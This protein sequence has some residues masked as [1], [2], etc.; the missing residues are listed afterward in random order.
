[1]QLRHSN[2]RK[3]PRD[4]ERSVRI[5]GVTRFR[6]LDYFF[7]TLTKKVSGQTGLR[8]GAKALKGRKHPAP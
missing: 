3:F 6:P 8:R 7:A 1:M 4:L 2:V 5:C